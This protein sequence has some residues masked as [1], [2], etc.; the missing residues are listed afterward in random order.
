MSRFIAIA[1]VLCTL[2]VGTP[3]LAQASTTTN[4]ALADCSISSLSGSSQQVV[5]ANPQRQYLMLFNS[6]ANTVYV[7]LAGG[8]AASSGASSIPL[9]VGA[10]VVV[11]GANVSR[12]AVTVTGTSTQPITCYEG[13]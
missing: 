13:R 10:S 3:D 11:N 8:T 7:N 4:Y 12:S 2:F 1:L 9:G 6:G 5:A